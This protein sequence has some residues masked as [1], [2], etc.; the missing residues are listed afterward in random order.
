MVLNKY[1]KKVDQ[2]ANL[3]RAAYFIA[4]GVTDVGM[5]LIN[6]TEI[7]FPLMNLS[8][9][10]KRKYWAEKILDK[11]MFLKMML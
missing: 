10:V 5:N 9:E 4:T 3:Y 1:S 7:S 2:I 8:T 11:Y 6:K